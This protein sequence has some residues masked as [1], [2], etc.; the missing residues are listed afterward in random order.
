MSQLQ[1]SAVIRGVRFGNNI[2]GAP[3]LRRNWASVKD[4]VSKIRRNSKERKSNQC[5]AAIS[6]KIRSAEFNIF[7]SPYKLSTTPLFY[8]AQILFC[9]AKI[10]RLLKN[11]ILE[12]AYKNS[13]EEKT[14]SLKNSTIQSCW[15]VLGSLISPKRT[16]S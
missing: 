10:Q 2:T 3:S 6:S 15:T 16:G 4:A 5:K 12:C 11:L 14:V 7:K 1:T 8:S 13:V 9:K